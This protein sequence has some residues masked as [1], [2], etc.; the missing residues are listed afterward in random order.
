MNE[1]IVNFST[2]RKKAANPKNCFCFKN[3]ISLFI[4]WTIYLRKLCINFKSFGPAVLENYAHGILKRRTVCVG[5]KTF[6]SPKIFIGSTAYVCILAK[7]DFVKILTRH[8]R[9]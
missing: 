9:F 2:I 4:T 1:K 3:N 8:N 7:I 6:V 5:T